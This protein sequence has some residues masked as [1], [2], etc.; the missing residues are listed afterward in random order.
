MNEARLRMTRIPK[1]A[2]LILNK[3]S[4]AP[5]FRLGNV[6]VCTAITVAVV[7]RHGIL[8][9]FW[10]SGSDFFEPS[11]EACTLNRV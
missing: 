9:F 3:V 6:H 5:G 2:D 8:A 7:I 10:H 11:A 4:A 1:G